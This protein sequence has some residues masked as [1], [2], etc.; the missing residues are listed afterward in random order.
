MPRPRKCRY[1][2][3]MPRVIFFKPAGIPMTR[4]DKVSLTVDEFE[5]LRWADIE[6]LRHSEA[7]EKMGVSRPTFTRILA[8]AH[9]KVATAL[10]SGKALRINGGNYRV[11]ERPVT[12]GRS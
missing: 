11:V 1:I 3:A 10:V 12:A 7:A 2:S 9:Q 4:L 5:A 8:R 6:D